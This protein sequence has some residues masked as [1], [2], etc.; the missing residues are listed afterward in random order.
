MAT[1]KA[2]RAWLEIMSIPCEESDGFM[3]FEVIW[4]N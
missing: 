3:R 2:Q 4:V 1:P